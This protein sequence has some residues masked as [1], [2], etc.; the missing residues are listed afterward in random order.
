MGGCHY[1][2]DDFM[3]LGN[4]RWFIRNV[5]LAFYTNEAF[6]IADEAR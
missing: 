1:P 3:G 6:T 5:A 2:M 4:R